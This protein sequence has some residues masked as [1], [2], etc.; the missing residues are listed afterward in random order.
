ML[1]IYCLDALG[2]V[3]INI[4][5][6]KNNYKKLAYKQSLFDAIYTV[7]A[8]WSWSA[9]IPPYNI[10][11]LNKCQIVRKGH[12]HDLPQYFVNLR[13]SILYQT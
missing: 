8:I 11:S 2:N 5:I 3:Q 1:N 12:S 7:E 6:S 13:S 10:T 4:F 9:R